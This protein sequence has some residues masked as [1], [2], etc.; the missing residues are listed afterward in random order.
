MTAQCEVLYYGVILPEEPCCRCSYEAVRKI[1]VGCVHEHMEETWVCT[2]HLLRVESRL[3]C[4]KCREK[5][6]ETHP[7]AILEI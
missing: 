3:F 4:S 7:L 1:T 5:T 2:R 6:G